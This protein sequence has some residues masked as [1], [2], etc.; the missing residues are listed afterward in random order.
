MGCLFVM[1]QWEIQ[2][3]NTTYLIISSA[4]YGET[5]IP[6][7]QANLDPPNSQ[8]CIRTQGAVRFRRDGD[9]TKFSI[10]PRQVYNE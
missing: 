4:S 6:T 7:I 5:S 2:V 3:I 8:M 10:Y 1:N 9:D